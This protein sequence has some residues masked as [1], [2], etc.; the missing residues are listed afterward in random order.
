MIRN[1]RMVKVFRALI[2]HWSHLDDIPL[3]AEEATL[4]I[5]LGLTRL[6][7]FDPDDTGKAIAFLL[8]ARHLPV[9]TGE[10]ATERQLEC[11]RLIAEGLHTVQSLP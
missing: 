4:C 5:H 6:E 7:D 9:N 8:R 10:K 2:A 3:E 11:I 1:S